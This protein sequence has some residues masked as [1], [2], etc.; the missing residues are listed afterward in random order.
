MFTGLIREIGRLRSVARR[1]GVRR[2]AV[3]APKLASRLAVGDSVAVNGIC[4]TVTVLSGDGFRVDAAAETSRVTTLPAWRPGDRLHLEP[5]LRLG[6]PIDGH[7]VLGH[8]DGVGRVVV[9]RRVGGSLFA[10]VKLD[11]EL[12]RFLRPKG[13]IAVDG[14]SLTVDAGPFRDRFTV[15][16]IP[17]TLEWTF[18]D[19]L[20]VGQAVNLELDVL[21]K[22]AAG[23]DGLHRLWSGTVRGDAAPADRSS[24]CEA[25]NAPAQ[26]ISMADIL[27]RGWSRG[28]GGGS[29]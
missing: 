7:L 22:S 10:T 1:R 19:R 11:R 20:R 8:V 27:D 29:R 13:S 2:L 6:D 21:V 26:R 23:G 16:L 24:E 9:I 25:G 15:N 14:V 4:L 3:T 5:S 18:F 12:A 28:A 17:H